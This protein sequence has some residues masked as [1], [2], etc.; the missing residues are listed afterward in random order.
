VV[1]SGVYSEHR[2]WNVVLG[3]KAARLSMAD[4]NG[5]EFFMLIPVPQRGWRDARN[6]ALG[7]IQEAMEMGLQPG[8]VICD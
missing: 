3:C 6:K 8:E 5:R 2:H 7:V 4:D 1:V